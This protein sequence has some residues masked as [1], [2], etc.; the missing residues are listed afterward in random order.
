MVACECDCPLSD[1]GRSA[2]SQALVKRL[3]VS[4]P[5]CGVLVWE[6][7]DAADSEEPI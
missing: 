1:G 7:V 3:G 2:E 5:L 6:L 4:P